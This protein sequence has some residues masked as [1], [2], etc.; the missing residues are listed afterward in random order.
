LLNASRDGL[1]PRDALPILRRARKVVVLT[2]AAHA[3]SGSSD[4]DQGADAVVWL[5]R[6]GVSATAEHQEVAADGDVGRKIQS[7]AADVGADLIVMGAYG[8]SRMRE[9]ALG[10]V[11]RTMFR[12]MTV[13]VLMAH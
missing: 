12:F 1:K 5:V 8:R 11:T 3:A 6:Q 13:P 9:L 7:R 2:V 10:G 4:R